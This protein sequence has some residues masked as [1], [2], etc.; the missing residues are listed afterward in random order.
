KSIQGL[1]ASPGDLSALHGKE[2]EMHVLQMIQ[3]GQIHA[4]INQKD[5]MVR[6]LEDPEQYK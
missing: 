6:F 4:L 3:D 1:S 5:G 2:A